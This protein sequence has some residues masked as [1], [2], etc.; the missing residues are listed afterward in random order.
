MAI[1]N[2]GITATSAAAPTQV[3]SSSGSNAV[4]T[5]IACN[6]SA[7]TINLTLYAVP[8][9]KSPSANPETTIVGAL[10]IPAGETVSFD[11]EK[12]VFG[13][14]DQLDAIASVAYSAGLGLVITVS[15]LAV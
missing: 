14:G 2:V 7:S 6:T 12:V 3:Y 1:T 8:A 9:G 13:N 5:I 15:T 10:P 4:T 11:Q